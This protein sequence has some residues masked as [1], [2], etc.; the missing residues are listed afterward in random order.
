MKLRPIACSACVISSLETRDGLLRHASELTND[1]EI[2]VFQQLPELAALK[3]RLQ[4]QGAA[5]AAMSGSGSTMVGAFHD[6]AARDSALAE[7]ID[8]RCIAASTTES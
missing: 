4:Q 7:F 6:V 1:F 3:T 8:V 5:W 2:P